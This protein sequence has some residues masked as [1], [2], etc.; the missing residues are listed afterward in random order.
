MFWCPPVQVN[1]MW[2]SGRLQVSELVVKSWASG[3]N[4]IAH[5]LQIILEYMYG[6]SI[7]PSPVMAAG[8]LIQEGALFRGLQQYGA[9]PSPLV[10]GLYYLINM[11]IPHLLVLHMSIIIKRQRQSTSAS[12]AAAAAGQG[13]KAVE[14]QAQLSGDDQLPADAAAAP[15]GGQQGRL[16]AKQRE[17]EQDLAAIRGAKQL[18]QHR[19]DEHGQVLK[20][21]AS[22]CEVLPP[23][24]TNQEPTV[25]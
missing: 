6:L 23:T 20:V 13:L 21:S 15:A 11:A 16:E 18:Q 3:L 9:A 24:D 17:A 1:V 25:M 4:Y 22:P 19:R 7:L 14:G 10:W 8:F 2:A 5:T 12:A